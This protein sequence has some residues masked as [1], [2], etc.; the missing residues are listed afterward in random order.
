MDIITAYA[1]ALTLYGNAQRSE[2]ITNLTVAEFSMRQDEKEGFVVIPCV[3][4]KTGSQGLA[5]L[6]V[7]EDCEHMLEYYYN[8]IKIKI[9]P[10]QD[11]YQG[12]FFLTF[13]G[14]EY[15]QV[16]RRIKG[17]LSTRDLCPPQP[18]HYCILISSEAR[19]HLNEQKQ[20][21]VVKHLSHSM[22]T[23]HRYYEFM[24]TTDATKAHG[25]IR[26]PSLQ[27]R[28]SREDIG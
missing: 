27:R 18:S 15:T 13:N 26:M 23:S 21:N 5:Q 3:H 7:T 12:R 4:H 1:A 11:I 10:A 9:K 24:D 22:Q 16:Y 6:V 17:A 25:T 28:W 14:Q 19:R 8:T 20:R 2:V